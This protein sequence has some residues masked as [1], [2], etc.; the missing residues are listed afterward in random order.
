V[1]DISLFIP[2]GICFAAF[3]AFVARPSTIKLHADGNI[4]SKLIYHLM[5]TIWVQTC[6]LCD[7]KKLLKMKL[8]GR[9]SELSTYNKLI[10]YK[11]VLRPVWSYG[12]QLW[13]CASD[14][15]IQV[16]QLFQNKVLKRIVQAPWLFVTV[17]LIGT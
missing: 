7:E 11:Q 5:M 15:N 10:L 2:E 12:I 6:H 3:V 16:I 4:T 13:G 14:S 8:L 1:Y 17:T 9:N